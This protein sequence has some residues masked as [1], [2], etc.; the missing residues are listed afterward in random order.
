M[1]NPKAI[2]I[3]IMALT[4]SCYSQNSKLELNHVS[5]SGVLL[6]SKSDK[7]LTKFGNPSRIEQIEPEMDVKPYDKYFYGK[8]FFIV[9]SGILTGFEINDNRFQLDQGKIKVGESISKVKTAFKNELKFSD[10]QGKIRIGTS[11][12]YLLFTFLDSKLYSFSIYNE[13]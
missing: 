7:L 4:T 6:G 12:D 10:D 2:I 8:S 13:E 5:I 9:T 1:I 11:D 3:I